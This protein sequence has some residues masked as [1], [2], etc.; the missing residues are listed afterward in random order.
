MKGISVK[1]LWSKQWGCNSFCSIM[2]RNKFTEIMRFLRFELKS[3]RNERRKTD[4][5]CLFS[6]I[7]CR[8]IENS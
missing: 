8:F 3:T 2:S 4:K 1:C 7:W 6:E 5:F